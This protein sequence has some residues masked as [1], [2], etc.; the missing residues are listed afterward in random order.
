MH[1]VISSDQVGNAVQG[2]DY[3]ILS[4]WTRI[5][6]LR[7]RIGVS[8]EFAN[9]HRTRHK[10]WGTQVKLSLLAWRLSL[11]RDCPGS[12]VHENPASLLVTLS[13]V[14]E[15]GIAPGLLDRLL[16]QGILQ[17]FPRCWRCDRHGNKPQIRRPA[18]KDVG[19]RYHESFFSC[20]TLA[21]PETI[22]S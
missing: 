12:R 22:S 9:H 17:E 15:L 6:A 16:H 4:T 18:E 11:H 10:G 7:C 20:Y 19:N 8:V 5:P 2:I 1:T 13:W 3:L 14:G 21:T